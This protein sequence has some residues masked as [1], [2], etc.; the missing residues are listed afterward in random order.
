MENWKDKFPKKARFYETAR[1]ILYCEDCYEILQEFPQDS[2]DLVVIDPPYGVGIKEKREPNYKDDYFAVDLID[3]FL[4]KILKNNSRFYCFI[5]QKTLVETIKGFRSFEL[6]QILIAYY[7]NF[8]GGGKRTYDFTHNYDF[9]LDFHKGKP[10]PLRRT[11]GMGGN[12]SVLRYPL[13]Q[14]NYKKEKR[15]HVNQKPLGLLKH[16]ISASCEDNFIVLD[17]FS[18][19]GTTLLAC[20]LLGLRWIGVERERIYCEFFKQRI[21]KVLCKKFL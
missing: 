5:A 10:C 15:F 19:V 1:G 21:S 20:E 3:K 18:G 6:H 14:S 9:I 7:P 13:P 2:V 8:V 16:I 11:P 12:S 17:C 4:S